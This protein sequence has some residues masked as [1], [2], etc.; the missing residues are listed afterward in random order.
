[1]TYSFSKGP[2]LDYGPVDPSLSTHPFIGI[3][4]FSLSYF[5]QACSASWDHFLEKL[6]ASN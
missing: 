2:K 6:P 3:S 4:P 5:I 1:M